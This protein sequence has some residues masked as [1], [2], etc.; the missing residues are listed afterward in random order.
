MFA[1]TGALFSCAK[2]NSIA[3]GGGSIYP[4]INRVGTTVLPSGIFNGVQWSLETVLGYC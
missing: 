4:H 1:R 3:I 2:V